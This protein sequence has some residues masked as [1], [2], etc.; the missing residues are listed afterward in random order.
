MAP[1]AVTAVLLL[2]LQ[3]WWTLSAHKHLHEDHLEDHL[4]S[5]HD[6]NVLLG[7]KDNEEL[8]RLSPEEQ[9]KKLM[10][11]VKK[12]DTN[13]DNKLS[14]EEI[15]LWI[16][17]VYRKYALDDTEERFP[18]FDANQDGVVTWEEYSMDKLFSFDESTVVDDAEQDSLRHLHLKER[19]RFN[20]ADVDG[21]PGLN[22]TEFLAFTHPSEVDHMADFAI[23]DVLSEYDTDQDGL[24]SLKEFIGDLRRDEDAPSQWEVEETVRFNDLYDQDKDGKLNREEQLRWIAPNSYGSAREEAL[25]LIKELDRDEDGQI[26][27]AEVL[28]NQETFMNSEVTDY[29]RHLHLSHDEL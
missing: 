26:S 6:M 12:I 29:G 1:P 28:K 8:K 5:E 14:A 9:R 27:E 15:T 10:D 13:A 24:I 20:F 23:E 21:T 7:E 4:N 17:H 2:V 3:F 18:E 11:I 22:V 16:Q 19:R 25:Y